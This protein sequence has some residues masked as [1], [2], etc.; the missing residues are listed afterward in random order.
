MSFLRS[1]LGLVLL[2]AFAAAWFFVAGRWTWIQGWLFLTLLVIY[3]N[4][5][6]V[7]LARADPALFAER[8][9]KAA[10]VEP[11]DVPI[12]RFYN[13]FFLALLIVAALDSGRYGWS[14]VPVF[15]QVTGWFFLGLV[16]VVVWHVMAVNTYLSTLVRLQ[17][18]R[19]HRVISEGLYGWVRHPMYVGV[20]VS[21]FCTPLALA[22]FWALIPGALM[23]LVITYRTAR[24]DHMLREKLEGYEAYAERVRY[25]LIPGVW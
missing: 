23:A 3:T 15:A 1:L 19:G 7:W 25:R 11:W 4:A 6:A 14:V 18:D 13:L 21:S 2:A 10:N 17:D 8:R 16:C 12:I 9:S 5:L 24:E 20:I 22:S